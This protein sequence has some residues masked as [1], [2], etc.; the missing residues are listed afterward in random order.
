M[1]WQ[2]RKT[3]S[4]IFNRIAEPGDQSESM[5]LFEEVRNWPVGAA[6]ALVDARLLREALPAETITCRGCEERCCRPIEFV[7]EKRQVARSTCHLFAHLGPFEHAANHLKR[8]V[9]SREM[10]V[11]FVRRVTGLAIREQDERWRRIRYE[12]LSNGDER[13]E[14]S[15]EFNG[16]ARSRI[17]S[18]SIDLIELITWEET[19][20]KLDRG[21]VATYF[22]QSTD[23]Q[24]GNKSIQP[25]T[26][27]RDDKKQI[28]EIRTRRLQ[29]A[30]EVLA[31]LHPNANKSAL[32]KL[33][34]KSND[35]PNLSAARIA[36]LTRMPNK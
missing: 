18:S 11:R 17:G 15:L 5:F 6:E 28:T 16:T 24:L 21:A 23:L 3:L 27:L 29:R 34:E 2:R 14:F 20:I 25:S 10:A 1:I 22:N 30:I 8:W 19:G 31:T 12:K 9:G 7:D 13:R 33:I 26:T 36:R 32:A 4:V 35:F